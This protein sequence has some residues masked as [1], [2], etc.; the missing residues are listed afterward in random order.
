[1]RNALPTKAGLKMFE[2]RPPKICFPMLIATIE[3]KLAPYHF[4]EG[5]KISASRRPVKIA[6]KS[7]MQSCFFLIF[8]ITISVTTALI[9]QF[10]MSQ[11]ACCPKK[12]IE[13]AVAGIRAIITCSII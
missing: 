9:I 12:Y 2:P 5:G 6:L 4:V 3:P 8:K 11:I 13:A 7:L 1:M 10:D